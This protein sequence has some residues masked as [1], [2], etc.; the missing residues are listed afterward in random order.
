MTCAVNYCA[1]TWSQ[2]RNTSGVQAARCSE[3]PIAKLKDEKV[4]VL[5]LELAKGSALYIPWQRP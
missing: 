1:V 2:R 3:V 4:R 5:L